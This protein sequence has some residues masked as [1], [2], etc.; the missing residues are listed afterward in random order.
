MGNMS[1]MQGDYP[2]N[3]P[4]V[5]TQD[6]MQAADADIL[7]QLSAAPPRKTRGRP[8][9]SRN[10]PKVDDSGTFV[11]PGSRRPPASSDKDDAATIAKKIADKKRLAQDYEKKILESNEQIFGFLIQ[12][13]IPPLMFY[14]NGQPPNQGSK[15]N[16]NWT[17]VANQV[18]IPPHLAKIAGYTAAEIQSSTVGTS[19]TDALEGDSPIRLLVLVGAT[20]VVGVPYLRNLNDIRKRMVAMQQAANQYQEQQARAANAVNV[21]VVG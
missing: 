18:A 2:T 1:I 21:Q 19:I 13:G 3:G 11:P 6:A 10:K 5:L 4:E 20:I 15:I 8:V 9:G 17:E 12:A 14:K 7:A 16:T